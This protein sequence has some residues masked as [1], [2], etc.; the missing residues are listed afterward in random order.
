DSGGGGDAAAP[1]GVTVASA[2]PP[3]VVSPARLDSLAAEWEPPI[4]WLGRRPGARLELKREL[5]GEI[6]LR[7]LT[8]NARPGDPRQ[9]YVTVGTYPVG[10]GAAAVRGAA[11]EEGAA[12]QSGPSGSVLL[13]NPRRPENVY[14]AFPGSEYQIEIFAP[15]AGRALELAKSGKLAPVG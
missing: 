4:Y 2:F 10:G 6:Y 7:Y 5:S 11:R 13:A 1:Q 8:G 12:V 3:T 9:D 15:A 14:L